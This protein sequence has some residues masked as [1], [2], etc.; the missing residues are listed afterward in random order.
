MGILALP[1]L[2]IIG[3]QFLVTKSEDAGAPKENRPAQKSESRKSPE[4]PPAARDV[5]I[6]SDP[7]RANVTIEVDGT[8]KMEPSPT[9][10][11]LRP[12]RY[13]VVV[14]K[15]GY[16]RIEEE[17]EVVAEPGVLK[18][19]FQLSQS[20]PVAKP[21]AARDVLIASDPE[22]ANV[23]IEVDGAKKME[24]SPTVFQLRPGRY[25]V[26]VEKEGY[27]RIE[28]E[29]EV[30]AEP[31]VLKK[32]FQLTPSQ[33]VAKPRG[34]G[35]GRGYGGGIGMLLSNASVQQEL[36]LDATQIEKAKEVAEKARE[37][38]TASRESLQSLEG[39]ARDQEDARAEQGS[40]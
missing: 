13:R 24:P 22:R 33:P 4:S 9:V 12:G 38:F 1:V 19:T 23:T 35:G 5:L 10:F 2:L 36:K 30:V 14:E 28:E 21:P 7:E 11:Q 39:D 8:K 16:G 27:G 29:I 6:A 3:S 18:K 37:K 34:G 25:R 26:V 15:E 17:I 40:E 31:G 32:T 20:Q